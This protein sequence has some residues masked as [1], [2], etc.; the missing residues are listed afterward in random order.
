MKCRVDPNL[1]EG[2]HRCTGL[3]P[4]LFEV[5]KDSKARL[6]GNIDVV[7]EDYEMDAQSAANSCPAG[8]IILEF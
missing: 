1:C 8:A 2:H 4:E 5:G 3:Y 6:K 7:P